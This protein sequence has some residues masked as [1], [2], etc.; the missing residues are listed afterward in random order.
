MNRP[1]CPNLSPSPPDAPYVQE[2]ETSTKLEAAV[3]VD[4][5]VHEVTAVDCLRSARGVSALRICKAFDISALS[6]SV[7][8]IATSSLFPSSCKDGSPFDVRL[9]CRRFSWAE[10][11]GIRAVGRS[12]L[13]AAVGSSSTAA[14]CIT[15][16]ISFK[17]G[18]A[19][20][21]HTPTTSPP[22]R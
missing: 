17:F 22:T 11:I 12:P 5:V 20:F 19:T 6:L 14:A 10:I 8:G 13:I 1:S 7:S 4:E 21:A 15:E 3:A 16:A 2:Y 18:I 9:P